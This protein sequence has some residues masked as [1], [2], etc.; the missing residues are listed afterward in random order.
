[1]DN[2]SHYLS[3][4]ALDILSNSRGPLPVPMTNDY[5]FRALMQ[6]NNRVLSA[7]I[8]SL[9]HLDADDVTSVA[10]SNPIELGEDMDDKTCILDIKVCLN[11]H[12]VINLEMQVV[13]E[14]NW[15]ERSLCYLC[16]AFDN[17]NRGQNYEDIRSAIQIGLLNFTLFSESP[18]FFANYYMTNIKNHKI[19]SDKLRLSVLDLTQIHLATREDR[20]YGL[21]RWAAFFKAATWEELKMLAK[22]DLNLQ[23]A[24]VTVRQLTQDEKIRQMCEAREDYYRRTAGREALLQKTTLERDQ[25]VAREK[26]AVAERDHLLQLLKLHGIDSGEIGTETICRTEDRENDK[27]GI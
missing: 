2:K 6:R 13:N 8:C 23:E 19:Y 16:R 1:M 22:T 20:N 11:G 10:I 12:T 7:L 27:K 18:E 14:G 9:L 4:V 21:H 26:K 15:P 25:A 5:L 24:V 17:L 3:S